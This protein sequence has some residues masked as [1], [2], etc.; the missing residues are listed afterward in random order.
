[1]TNQEKIEKS[2]E[3]IAQYEKEIEDR[4]KKIKKLKAE[5]KALEARIDKEFADKI[6]QTIIA[7]GIS[8]EEQRESILKQ[9]SSLTA[10][11]PLPT[12]TEKSEI[13]ENSF[14]EPQRHFLKNDENLSPKIFS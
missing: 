13:S 12:E 7:Q 14:A 3:K 11:K 6:Y 10:D 9:I 4:K 2:K 8:S 1:M 5:I